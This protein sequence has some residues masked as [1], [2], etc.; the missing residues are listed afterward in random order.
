M[1]N[2]DGGVP[3]E[4]K[5]LTTVVLKIRCQLCGEVFDEEF[6]RSDAI[7]FGLDPDS[8]DIQEYEDAWCTRCLTNNMTG[9]TKD[10][11]R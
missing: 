9:V 10:W 6:D 8:S 2:V 11:S 7:D 3:I 5:P 1:L 4:I